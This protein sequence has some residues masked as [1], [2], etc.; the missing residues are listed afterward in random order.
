MS[1]RD[2]NPACTRG[3]IVDPKRLNH[4]LGLEIEDSN[5]ESKDAGTKRDARRVQLMF[6]QNGDSG[7]ILPGQAVVFKSGKYGTQ[8]VKAS[9]SAGQR[10][11]GIADFMLP[12]SGVPAGYGFLVVIDGPTKMINDA[13]GALNEGD[14]LVCSPTVAGAVR[15]QSASPAQGSEIPQ[16][17][18]VG[19]AEEAAASGATFWGYFRRSA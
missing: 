8:V 7:A 19:H 14:V 2:V 17:R 10:I 9:A 15:A 4:L 11:E 18:T 1:G 12:A 16:T 13:N 5:L 6:V 3:E